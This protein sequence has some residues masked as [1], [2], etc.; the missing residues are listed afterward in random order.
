MSQKFW[1]FNYFCHS[2][3]LAFHFYSGSFQCSFIFLFHHLF[4]FR[5]LLFFR[6]PSI[7]FLLS[8]LLN[9]IKLKLWQL[10]NQLFISFIFVELKLQK[11]QRWKWQ[12][13][14]EKWNRFDFNI[15]IPIV[16]Y[17]VN[18]IKNFI[19]YI[20]SLFP[21]FFGFNWFNLLFRNICSTLINNSNCLYKKKQRLE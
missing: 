19:N 9:H 21:Y 2:L 18:I 8:Q 16:I 7:L 4:S 3:V 6:Q 1:Q 5:I 15:L 11:F 17:I 13:N 10:L 12:R 14:L 20:Y